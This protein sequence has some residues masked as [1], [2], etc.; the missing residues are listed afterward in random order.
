MHRIIGSGFYAVLVWKQVY[1]LPILAWNRVW[2]SRE[3]RERMKL[4]IVSIPN[5]EERKRNMQIRNR[6]EE[7]FCLRS[8]LSND[9]IISA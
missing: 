5:E 1:T 6:F 8:N 9:G 2:F 7:F 4:F 3:L